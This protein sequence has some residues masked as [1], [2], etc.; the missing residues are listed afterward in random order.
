MYKLFRAPSQCTQSRE[1]MLKMTEKQNIV[2]AILHFCIFISVFVVFF[3]SFASDF[4]LR[5][6]VKIKCVAHWDSR[7]K[8]YKLACGD[9]PLFRNITLI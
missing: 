1:I 2:A 8:I 9:D 7:G 3:A 4:P 5:R 6:Y